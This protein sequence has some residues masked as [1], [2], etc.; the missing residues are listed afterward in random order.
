VKNEAIYRKVEEKKLK[1]DAEFAAINAKLEAFN[2]PSAETV[3]IGQLLSD[4][5]GQPAVYG[6][7]DSGE[8]MEK[9]VPLTGV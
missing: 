1:V 2:K 5:L 6:F 3:A 8:V 9:L 4:V 7:A